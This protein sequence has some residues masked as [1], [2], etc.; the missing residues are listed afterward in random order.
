M[1]AP[2]PEEES[3]ETT[4]PFLS[5]D[6]HN[7]QSTHGTA[8]A[9]CDPRAASTEAG[10]GNEAHTHAVDECGGYFLFC[11]QDVIVRRSREVE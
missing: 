7:R 10:F 1:I 6:V 2:P 5:L 11:C 8:V 3:S 4:S 9:T